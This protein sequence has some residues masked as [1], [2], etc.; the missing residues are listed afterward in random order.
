MREIN[1]YVTATAEA[2]TGESLLP[3]LA[4]RVHAVDARVRELFGSLDESS[5]RGGGDAAGSA[6]GRAAADRARLNAGDVG[7]ER[8]ALPSG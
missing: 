6:R 5:G 7:R 1:E 3:V 4:A 8:L 2:E